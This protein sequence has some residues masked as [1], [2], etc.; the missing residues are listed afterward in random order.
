MGGLRLCT[1]L[2]KINLNLSLG[3]VFRSTYSFPQTHSF[4][5]DKVLVM[6]AESKGCGSAVT[7][8]CVCYLEDGFYA[9]NLLKVKE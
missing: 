2:M 9:N 3:R 7:T 8:K 4:T 6:H 1:F 5:L